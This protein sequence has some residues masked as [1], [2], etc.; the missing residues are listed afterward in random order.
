MTATTLGRTSFAPSVPQNFEE[1]GL[2]RA[3]LLDLML[4]RLLLEGMSTLEI[5]SRSLRLSIPILNLVFQHMRQQQLLE[6]KG[7]IGNDY[8]FTLSGSGKVLA[9][10]RFQITQYAG[11]APVSLKEYQNATKAQSARLQIDRKALRSAFSDLIVS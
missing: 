9:A 5:L 7:M 8:Q 4:R 1:L 2:S 6:V 3:L 11:A 10:E